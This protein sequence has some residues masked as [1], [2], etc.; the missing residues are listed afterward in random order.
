MHERQN[1]APSFAKLENDSEIVDWRC[2]PDVN[3]R[4]RPA[5]EVFY[6]KNGDDDDDDLYPLGQF[7]RRASMPSHF[8]ENN[9]RSSNPSENSGTEVSVPIPKKTQHAHMMRELC[10]GMNTAVSDPEIAVR[11]DRTKNIKAISEDVR[12]S[13]STSLAQKNVANEKKVEEKNKNRKKL[14][15][16]LES[17]RARENSCDSSEERESSN[18]RKAKREDSKRHSSSG[19]PKNS[20]GSPQNKQKKVAMEEAEI[21]IAHSPI[22]LDDAKKQNTSKARPLPIT[23]D[24][25]SEILRGL[26]LESYEQILTPDIV[27]DKVGNEQMDD[28]FDSA[29]ERLSR[30]KKSDEK[31]FESVISAP[32]DPEEHGKISEEEKKERS[33]DSPSGEIVNNASSLGSSGSLGLLD[34][35]YSITVTGSVN[36]ETLIMEDKDTGLDLSELMDMSNMKKN[37]KAMKQRGEKESKVKETTI[38]FV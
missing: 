36:D 12:R 34:S 2:H 28:S 24:N 37:R 19:L 38:T 13:K 9:S 27:I 22:Y 8:F 31:N 18:L 5:S 32:L 30:R 35:E 33:C 4:F 7:D 15:K 16:N 25:E 3:E 17:W 21:A 14:Q 29:I 1:S 6:S 10:A 20:P 11:R 23:I 26:D